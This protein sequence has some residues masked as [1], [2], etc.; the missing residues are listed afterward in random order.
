M[1]A[2]DAV[3][4]DARKFLGKEGERDAGAGKQQSHVGRLFVGKRV[5]S[6]ETG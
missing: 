4:D 6:E 2:N 1:G 3:D 5:V